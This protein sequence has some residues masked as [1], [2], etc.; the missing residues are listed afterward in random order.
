MYSAVCFPR[1]MLQLWSEN[2]ASTLVT[3]VLFSSWPWVMYCFHYLP[4]YSGCSL[5]S[6]LILCRCLSVRLAS[7]QVWAASTGTSCVSSCWSAASE[8]SRTPSIWWRFFQVYSL[9]LLSVL[10]SICTGDEKHEQVQ[11]ECQLI[12]KPFWLHFCSSL[13]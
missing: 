11:P 5:C 3:A 12:A 2:C 4:M 1:W 8:E 13:L 6:V 10:Y 7:L 9:C